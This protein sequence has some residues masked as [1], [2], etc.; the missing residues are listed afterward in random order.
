MTHFSISSPGPVRKGAGATPPLAAF[1]SFLEAN[2]GQWGL[3]HTYPTKQS[4]HQRVT[5]ANH[6]Y[7]PRGFTFTS[8]VTPDGV[9]VYGIFGITKTH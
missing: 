9:A 2:P 4:G 3:Y 8:R 5:R 6:T 7:G 1:I